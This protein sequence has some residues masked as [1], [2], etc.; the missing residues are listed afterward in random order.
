VSQIIEQKEEQL[1]LAMLNGDVVALADLI[2]EDLQFV[3]YNGD[4]ISKGMDLEAHRSR[5]ID[6][7]MIQTS[8]T[9]IRN[10]GSVA[11]VTVRVKLEG[12]F[13]GTPFRGDYR[14]CRTWLLHE[15]RWQVIAGSV[16]Q[17]AAST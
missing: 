7:H 2:S 1:R 13:G 5:T 17:I 9:V 12:V 11:V 6:L 4:L 16:S 14:Y 3:M 15:K 8:E 10:F